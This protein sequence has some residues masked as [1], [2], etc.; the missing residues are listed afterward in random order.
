M[1]LWSMAFLGSR[2]IAAIIDGGVADLVSPR[3]GVLTAAV[4]LLVGWWALGKV[5]DPPVV[6]VRPVEETPEPRL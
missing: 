2:P 5:D 6:S 4:P 1:A 3:V